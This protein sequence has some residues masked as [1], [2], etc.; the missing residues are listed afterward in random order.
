MLKQDIAKK[1]KDIE[2]EKFRKGRHVNALNDMNA[3]R[4]TLEIDGHVFYEKLHTTMQPKKI[5]EKKKGQKIS[6][7]QIKKKQSNAE[8][9]V[10]STVNRKKNEA[11]SNENFSRR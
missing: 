1:I 10:N 7:R 5:S 3:L 9:R 6:K 11:S 4:E 8:E 2:A